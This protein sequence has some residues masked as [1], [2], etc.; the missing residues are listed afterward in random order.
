MSQDQFEQNLS[1]RNFLKAAT[2]T[3]V[4]ATATGAGA[5]LLRNANPSRPVLPPP[6]S[7]PLPAAVIG[8][9][10]EAAAELF[11][12]LAEAQAENMRLSAALDAA[13]RRL[14]AQEQWGDKASSSSEALSIELEKASQQVGVLAGLVALYEQLDHIN[15]GEVLDE[16]LSSVSEALDDLLEG[17]PA[18]AEGI[19]TGRQALAEFE[20]QLPT[21]E[22]GRNWLEEQL[23]TL[24]THLTNVESLLKAAVDASGP[25]LQMLNE[26]FQSVL[27]WLP[28]GIGQRAGEIMQAMT[29]VMAEAP[30]TVTGGSIHV[31]Q[32]LEAWVGRQGEEAPL[33]RRLITPLRDQV[34]DHAAAT[35]DKAKQ[36]RTAYKTKLATPASAA[37]ARQHAI[38]DLIAEYRQRHQI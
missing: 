18:L 6:P 13:Q 5:A 28:F 3:A 25:F 24:Q 12:Q 15:L 8:E 26:W 19:E 21:L 14:K 31:V 37:I 30:K 10:S 36:T 7:V 1:R 38:R 34:L 16:G 2:V 17:A 33:R 4:A 20:A 27:K 9:G 22:S 32:P 23:D 35:V 11:A 29:G